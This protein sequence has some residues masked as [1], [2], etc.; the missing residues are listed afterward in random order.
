MALVIFNIVEFLKYRVWVFW[1]FFVGVFCFLCFGEGEGG[2][3][4]E[5]LPSLKWEL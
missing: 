2:R 5:Y 3:G 4:R 1:I